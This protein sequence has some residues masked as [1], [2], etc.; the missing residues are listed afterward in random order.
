MQ[1][2]PSGLK[3]ECVKDHDA[4]CRLLALALHLRELNVRKL[5]SHESL[6]RCGAGP[7]FNPPSHRSG[8]GQRGLASRRVRN[9][10]CDARMLSVRFL[11]NAE[12][13]V[14]NSREEECLT[15]KGFV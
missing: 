5:K 1:Y 4:N 11:Q 9:F 14:S 8:F 2:P 12:E 13:R 3:R 10:S 15:R 6:A 7:W